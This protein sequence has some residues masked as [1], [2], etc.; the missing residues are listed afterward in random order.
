M[1]CGSGSSGAAPRSLA[2]CMAANSRRTSVFVGQPIRDGSE[3]VTQR[4]PLADLGIELVDLTGHRSGDEGAEVKLSDEAS[5]YLAESWGRTLAAIGDA[6]AVAYSPEAVFHAGDNQ[7]LVINEDVREENVSAKL[8]LNDVDRPKKAPAEVDVEALYLY[9]VVSRTAAGRLAMIKKVNPARRAGSKRWALAR[10]ELQL[11]EEDPWQLHP[12]FDVVVGET[13]AFALSHTYFEQLFKDAERL[14]AK[15][16]E[17]VDAVD[18]ALPM[19]DTQKAVLV[20]RCRESSRLRRH[21]RAITNRGHLDRVTIAQVRTH[22]RRM[23]LDPENFIRSG[24]LVV[25]QANADELLQLLNEDLFVGGLTGDRF[26]SGGKEA[27]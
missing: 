26:R 27:M 14:R 22:A 25:D 10:D 12:T 1:R 4:D 8:L 15:V 19:T 17:W 20:E 7:M 2:A 23:D 6:E 16:D 11:L 9:A 13:G 5:N 21:L 24:K 3:P 18:A